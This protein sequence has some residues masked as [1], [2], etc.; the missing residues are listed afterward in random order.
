M[1]QITTWKR[2]AALL[3]LL[4]LAGLQARAGCT[5]V[6]TAIDQLDEAVKKHR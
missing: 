1:K 2:L 5:D 4:S 3:L 6:T